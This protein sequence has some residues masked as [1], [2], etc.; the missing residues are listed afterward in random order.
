MEAEWARIQQD[1]IRAVTQLSDDDQFAIVFSDAGI[2][3]FPW[4][5]RPGTATQR[6]KDAIESYVMSVQPGH[7]SCPEAALLQALWFAQE[8]S[9]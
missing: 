7:G 1:L 6:W 5:G 2:L 3:K 4:S 8:S 9:A